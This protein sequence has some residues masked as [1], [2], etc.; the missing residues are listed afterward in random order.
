MLLNSLIHETSAMK[1]KLVI[2]V[3]C[4]AFSTDFDSSLLYLTKRIKCVFFTHFA[5][6]VYYRPL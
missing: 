4:F 6:F 1:E 3:L 2:V 5:C